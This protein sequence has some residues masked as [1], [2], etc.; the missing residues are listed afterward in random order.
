MN[1]KMIKVI[2]ADDHPAVTYGIQA[3]LNRSKDKTV[4]AIAH[5]GDELFKILPSNPADVLL[6]DLNMPGDDYE[7]TIKKLR[8]RYKN[9]HILIFTAYNNPEI[10]KTVI[11]M[12]AD[13]YLLKNTTPDELDEAIETILKGEVYVTK[14]VH[15]SNAY[16]KSDTCPNPNE[17]KDG[18]QKKLGLSKREQEVFD[19]ICK[20]LTGQNIS[21][22]L[23]ISKHTVETHRKNIL[24]KLKISSSVELIRFAVKQGL[25]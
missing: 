25:V 6:L 3:I 1:K 2:I 7:Q 20:G 18:F 22:Q 10:A 12:G 17:I 14:T 15:L 9:L 8:K 21:T 4:C 11:K 5:S 13:G 24:R 19:L 16:S 23:N